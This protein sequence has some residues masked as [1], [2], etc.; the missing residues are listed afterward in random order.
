M[1]PGTANA[2]H[3]SDWVAGEEK[4]SPVGRPDF[5]SGKGREPVLG[6]FDSHSLPPKGPIV[7]A[8]R[9]LSYSR[10]SSSHNRHFGTIIATARSDRGCNMEI[11]YAH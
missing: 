2:L 1:L 5:K 10:P 4:R 11:Y 9:T 6:G 3:G 7:Q 8:P